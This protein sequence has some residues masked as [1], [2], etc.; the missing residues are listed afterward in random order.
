[1][2]SRQKCVVKF[3]DKTVVHRL[4]AGI[5][6]ELAACKRMVKPDDVVVGHQAEGQ[7]QPWRQHVHSA[8]SPSAHRPGE[9]ADGWKYPY[10]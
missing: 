1:M 3:A 2:G 4:A 7:K 5:L 9:A 6:H 8:I 10:A